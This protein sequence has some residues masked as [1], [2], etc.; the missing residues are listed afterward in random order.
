LVATNNHYAYSTPKRSRV[1]LRQPGR[2]RP[3]GYGFEGY[4]LDGT[5]LAQCL[6]II[7]TAVNRAP[8]PVAHRSSSSPPSSASPVM[9]NTTISVTSPTIFRKEPFA[10]DCL[11]THGSIYQGARAGRCRNTEALAPKKWQRK[12]KTLS[13]LRQKEPVPSGDEED[14]HAILH[15]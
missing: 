10:I 1:C 11:P 9:A 3:R 2:S 8:A 5:D 6:D 15:A 12:S 4:E 14:W 13:A 7:G